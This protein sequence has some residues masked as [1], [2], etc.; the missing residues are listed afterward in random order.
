M[1]VR[2]GVAVVD[3]MSV[4]AQH[5]TMDG[6]DSRHTLAALLA[7]IFTVVVWGI[8]PVLVRNVALAM[9]AYDFLIFR[10]LVSGLVFGAIL[11][12]VGGWRRLDRADWWRLALVSF[13]GML[14]YFGFSTYGYELVP[15]G[16]GTLIMSTQPML[17]ALLAFAA[18]M[19]RLTRF[20]ILGLVVAFA[21]SAL[22]VWGDD[23]V[24]GTVSQRDIVIGCLLIFLASAGWA[25]YVVFSRP[26]VKKHGPIAVSCLTNVLIIPAVLPLFRWSMMEK[27]AALPFDDVVS[28]FVL[29][30]VV[31]VTAFT[32]NYAAQHSRPSVL[33]ASL[34][35]MPVVAV[36]AGWLLLDEVVTQ[37][38]LLAAAIILAGVAISQV[39]TGEMKTDKV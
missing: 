31:V 10:L 28:L 13:A 34:Y 20:T 12:V 30:A 23:V 6:T 2:G 17:I 24:T 37:R 14:C 33:G 1:H 26:L 9:G 27:A 21:G 4:K 39:K 18:G 3:Q 32:W 29:F 36:V 35:V 5:M 19:E 38:V 16:I 8:T 25:L 15:A 22:L 11:L 7:L